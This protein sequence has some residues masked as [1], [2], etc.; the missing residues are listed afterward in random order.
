MFGGD[1]FF[2][3]HTDRIVGVGERVVAGEVIARIADWPGSQ[4]LDHVHVGRITGRPEE[5]YDWP[6]LEPRADA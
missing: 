4:S 3:T 5:L 1:V 2:F 6:K